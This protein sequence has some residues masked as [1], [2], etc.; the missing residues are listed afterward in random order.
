MDFDSKELTLRQAAEIYATQYAKSRKGFD[1][2]EDVQSFVS[3]TVSKFKDIADEPG[4]AVQLF[5]PDEGDAKPSP[6]RSFCPE[7]RTQV[8]GRALRTY[9]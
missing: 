7:S 3:A 4:S 5:I 1:S 2:P 6:D 9:A 8:Y